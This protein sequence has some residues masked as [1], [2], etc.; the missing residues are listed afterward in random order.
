MYVVQKCLFLLKQQYC[1]SYP[2][3]VMPSRWFQFQ[4]DY[5][6]MVTPISAMLM[7]V[8]RVTSFVILYMADIGV[9]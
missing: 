3:C 5:Q 7:G 1:L 2:V 8:A 4:K 6:W 9:A